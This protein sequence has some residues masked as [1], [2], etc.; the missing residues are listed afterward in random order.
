MHVLPKGDPTVNQT[1]ETQL[2]LLLNSDGLIVILDD[3]EMSDP[4]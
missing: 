2:K 3:Q 1:L 4:V